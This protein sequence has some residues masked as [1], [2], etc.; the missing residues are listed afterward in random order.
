MSVGWSDGT[1]RSAASYSFELSGGG[2]SVKEV[3]KVAVE[4][5]SKSG[6]V[7]VSGAAYAILVPED[8]SRVGGG[9]L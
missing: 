9:A 1:C 2:V 4:S 8:R 3:G 6:R 5:V 7:V